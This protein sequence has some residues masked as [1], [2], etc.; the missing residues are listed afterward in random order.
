MDA[1]NFGLV[2]M[3]LV[4]G[5]VL[6]L[7]V[8]ELVSVRRQLRRDALERPSAQADP[9]LPQADHGRSPAEDGPR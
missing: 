9:D 2:E 4:F 7:A 1:A 5:F 8:Y 3:V 6:A